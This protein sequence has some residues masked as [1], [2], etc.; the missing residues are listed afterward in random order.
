MD[1]VLPLIGV[2]I[3]AVLGGGVTFLLDR[4]RERRAAR[5]GLRLVVVE[6]RRTQSTWLNLT[7]AWNEAPTAETADW[8]ISELQGRPL[9]TAQWT[10]YQ[11]LLAASLSGEDWKALADAYAVIGL[12]NEAAHTALDPEFRM[13]LPEVMNETR[14]RLDAALERLQRGTG[15]QVG[16]DPMA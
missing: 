11:E 1:A 5:A 12:A 2:V 10:N 15:P 3:G 9:A 6:L 13:E 14:W 8:V 7:K 16:P 4:R